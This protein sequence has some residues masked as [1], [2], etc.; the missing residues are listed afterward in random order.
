MGKLDTSRKAHLSRSRCTAVS[1][2]RDIWDR[3][4]TQR[5]QPVPLVPYPPPDFLSPCS[6]P[7]TFSEAVEDQKSQSRLCHVPFLPFEIPDLVLGTRASVQSSFP[8]TMV[9]LLMNY[10][11]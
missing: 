6:P 10:C 9:K 1:N 7:L 2:F 4:R 8:K 3:L 11:I 5:R